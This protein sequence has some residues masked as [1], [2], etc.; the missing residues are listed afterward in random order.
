MR[1]EIVK[2]WWMSIAQGRDNHLLVGLY[3]G[4]TRFIQYISIPTPPR[5]VVELWD[6]QYVIQIHCFVTVI[7]P[8][9]T[10]KNRL[11]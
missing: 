1:G 9:V 5:D 8:K 6:Q 11:F 10:R 2:R 3:E 7:L 4:A